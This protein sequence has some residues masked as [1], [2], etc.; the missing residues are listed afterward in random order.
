VPLPSFNGIWTADDDPRAVAALEAEVER[1]RETGAPPGVMMRGDQPRVYAEAR[2]L[3]LT[4]SV[5][6]PGMI[7]ERDAFR[8]VE[9]PGTTIDT[10]S[11]EDARALLADSFD[12]PVEWFAEFYTREVLDSAHATVYVLRESGRP[13]STSLG[14]DGGDG[15]GIFNVGTPV[16]ERGRGFGAAVTSRAVADG[17]ASGARFAY[18]QSSDL[19]ESVYRRLGFEHVSTYVLAYGV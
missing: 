4:Q 3:G 16:L 14:F 18:L 7:A 2:R 5:G 15:L 9:A 1:V 13:A 8:P 10:D 11:L 17:F 12:I 6:M 19:G